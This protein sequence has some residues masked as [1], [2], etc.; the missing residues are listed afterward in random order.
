MAWVRPRRSRAGQEGGVAGNSGGTG[1]T[2]LPVGG[3]VA[4][5]G[6]D[7]GLGRCRERRPPFIDAT[8]VTTLLGWTLGN[9][10]RPKEHAT[11]CCDTVQ[12]E[13]ESN[14]AHLWVVSP[15]RHDSMSPIW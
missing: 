2:S 15:F 4:L 14:T 10:A 3:P 5:G 9:G 11:N 1:G 7:T 13:L 6:G 8:A 12:K